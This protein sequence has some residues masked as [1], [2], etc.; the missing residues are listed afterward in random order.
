MNVIQR[1][2][3][4]VNLK[5]GE[6]IIEKFLLNLYFYER[7]SNKDMAQMLMLPI[8]IITAIK[9]EATKEKLVIQNNGITLS[10][11]GTEYIENYLG[12]SNVD[13]K[14]YKKIFGH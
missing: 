2:Y 8:P 12:Y 13:K 7:L 3:E 4:N 10:Q 1:I 14:I 6:G 9:K 5:E 11:E